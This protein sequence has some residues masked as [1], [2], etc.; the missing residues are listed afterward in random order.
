MKNGNCALIEV[1]TFDTQLIDFTNS[2]KVYQEMA[3][4]FN[5]TL[6]N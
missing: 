6:K 2:V 1:L 3:N 5:K 4:Y